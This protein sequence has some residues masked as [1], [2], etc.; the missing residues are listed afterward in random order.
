[1]RLFIL[2]IALLAPAHL[3]SAYQT[4]WRDMTGW[5]R[6]TID[7][8]SQGADGVKVMDVDGNGLLDIV[9]GW[10]E[11]GVVHLYM[12]P[13]AEHVRSPWPGVIVGHVNSVEDAVLFHA[14]ENR[15][16]I[17]VSA[18]EGKERTLF[19]HRVPAGTHAYM[20]ASSWETRAIR[21]SKN[22]MQWMFVVPF[23]IGNDGSLQLVAAGKNA[24][25]E[26]GWFDKVDP[27][28]SRW[29]PLATVSWV[30][31]IIP[32]DIDM[33]GDLDIIYNDRKGERRGVYVATHEEGKLKKP[34]PLIEIEA[35]PMFM[36]VG[37]LEDD[38]Q[39]EIVIATAKHGIRIGK[40]IEAN[41][42]THETIP[43]PEWAG[44]GKGVAIG[45]LQGD[46]V[47]EIAVTSEHAR[48]K[49]GVY[50]LT[51]VNESWQA[52]DIGGLEGT[53]FDRIELLDL[54]GDGDLDLLTCE[55]SEN[56]G[57]IWYENPGVNSP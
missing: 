37:D 29:H 56:L 44:S 35:E 41:Q 7:A 9:T 33:D 17:V 5:Q 18:A 47:P 4:I 2:V 12:N 43:F 27:L 21:A 36:A 45:D 15:I 10:E 42:W 26:I 34:Q 25:A 13:G 20:D 22:R 6:H 53:K 23:D 31:S 8:S 28:S 49:H 16:P 30:M 57:V 39:D 52:V 50:F 14:Q 3:V 51:K 48:G 32:T 46:N 1:M 40:R 24:E 54:D 38:G 11:G 55:E 19:V